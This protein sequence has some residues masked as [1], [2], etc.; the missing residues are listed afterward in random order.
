M[1]DISKELQDVLDTVGVSINDDADAQANARM[2]REQLVGARVTII[3]QAA[4]AVAKINAYLAPSAEPPTITVTPAPVENDT[5]HDGG[6]VIEIQPQPNGSVTAQP[7]TEDPAVT[8]PAPVEVL[9]AT[10]AEGSAAADGAAAST[11]K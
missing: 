8:D 9:P 2:R 10:T 3:A 11:G 1:P 6:D 4:A 7:V 5:P